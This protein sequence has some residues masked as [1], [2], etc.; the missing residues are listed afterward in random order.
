[1]E[2]LHVVFAII[3]IGVLLVCSYFGYKKY[4]S[5]RMTPIYL[6][7]MAMKANDP[8]YFKYSSWERDI[9]GMSPRDYYL[10]N[11]QNYQ[12]MVAPGYFEGD[13]L[14]VDQTDFLGMPPE[15]RPLP[16]RPVTDSLEEAQMFDSE[17]AP[18]YYKTLVNAREKAIYLPPI[19]ATN[20]GYYYFPAAGTSAALKVPANAD[21]SA[22]LADNSSAAAAGMDAPTVT[23]QQTEE[24]RTRKV[25]G[26]KNIKGNKPAS[27]SAAQIGASRA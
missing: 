9:T 17:L 27:T 18:T 13:G 26:G 6:D 3:L 12:N 25:S 1:M 21:L 19:P 10:E 7:Q 15:S 14:Y 4:A 22:A 23:A 24:S 5:E 11:Q 8:M 2:G 20:G 16:N